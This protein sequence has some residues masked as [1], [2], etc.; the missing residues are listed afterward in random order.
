[1]NDLRVLCTDSWSSPVLFGLCKD[2]LPSGHTCLL[3][4]KCSG[5]RADLGAPAFS[6]LMCGGLLF[7]NF[8]CGSQ[9]RRHP[10]CLPAWRVTFIINQ[11]SS[12][13][14]FCLTVL[15]AICPSSLQSHFLEASTSL[16]CSHLLSCLHAVSYT[17]ESFL[18]RF[19]SA[20]LI[21][22]Y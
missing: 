8:L 12:Y 6:T 18:P 4:S 16:F 9:D 10:V 22:V 21:V 19:L 11:L 3:A 14:L 1:M 2:L 17:L 20:K 7:K 13:T 5:H 15:V